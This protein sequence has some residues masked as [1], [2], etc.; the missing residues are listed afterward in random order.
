[1]GVSETWFHELVDDN[2]IANPHYNLLRNDRTHKRGGGLCFYLKKNL[3]YEACEDKISSPDAE[4]FSVVVERTFQKNLL[5]TLLYRPP[6]GKVMMI[7][8]CNLL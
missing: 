5:I 3:K 2:I 4:I 8:R 1:M 6:I 7:K